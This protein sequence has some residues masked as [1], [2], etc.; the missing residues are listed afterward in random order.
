MSALITL[1]DALRTVQSG[2][3][4][5]AC[6]KYEFMELNHVH[7][8]VVDV[9]DAFATLMIQAEQ[10]G[11]T[12]KLEYSIPVLKFDVPELNLRAV[13]NALDSAFFE[14]KSLKRTIRDQ[15]TNLDIVQLAACGAESGKIEKSF[16]HLLFNQ[17]V[18][19]FDPD[20]D[21]WGQ[22]VV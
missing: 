8:A 2:I 1:K 5:A 12:W 16:A 6:F 3:K 20:R 11:G 15:Q 13:P 7:L 21:G 4:C 14:F 9:I 18:D 19:L 17:Q 22:Q 10:T